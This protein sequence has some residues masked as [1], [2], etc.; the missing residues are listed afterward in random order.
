MTLAAS[1]EHMAL[2][3]REVYLNDIPSRGVVSGISSSIGEA[4]EG[5][6]KSGRCWFIRKDVPTISKNTI[7]TID[8]T[9]Y[10][11]LSID[12]KEHITTLTLLATS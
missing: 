9:R 3:G 4:D 2:R 10:E 1:R 7:V 8:K 5:V 6:S 11:I 12:E